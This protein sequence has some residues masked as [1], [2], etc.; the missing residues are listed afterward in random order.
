MEPRSWPTEKDKLCDYGQD[1]I[2]TLVKHYGPFLLSKGLDPEA[3][4]DKWPELLMSVFNQ[5]V[6]VEAVNRPD[7]FIHLP[8][9]LF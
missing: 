8:L 2:E 4:A 1:D 5:A 3:I 7:V 9:A 6:N